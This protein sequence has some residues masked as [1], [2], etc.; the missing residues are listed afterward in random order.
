MSDLGARTAL[1]LAAL[2]AAGLAAA[3][4]W[5]PRWL[6]LAPEVAPAIFALLRDLDA[7]W[8]GRSK[9]SDGTLPS[10]AHHATSPG[11]DHERGDAL[12]VTR[13]P[14]RGP[15]LPDLATA[16]LRDPRAA[17]VILDRRI[18]HA[19]AFDGRAPGEWGEYKLTAV[20]TDPHVTHLHLSV[21]RASRGGAGP[22]D[23]S[24]VGTGEE[25]TV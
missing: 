2:A 6:G 12:D 21:V 4:R 5:R 11:S 13:D 25:A 3:W 10:A 14:Y 22:W 18:A 24:G 20:Q 19:G 17:Y 15:S 9:A 16:L 1:G 7:R 23:L 8:P